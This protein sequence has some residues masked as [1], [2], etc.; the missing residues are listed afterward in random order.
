M[1]SFKSKIAVKIINYFFLNPEASHYVNELAR[2]LE[3]DPKNVYR[4]LR[5]LEKEGLF[6]SEFR[7]QQ[8]YFFIAKDYPLLKHYRQ[9]FLKTYG[10]EA[11][12]K[13]LMSDI[14]DIDEAYVYGSYASGKMDASSDID[15]L[16]VGSHSVIGLQKV[17]VGLQKEIGREINVVNLSEKEFKVKKKQKDQFL[18]NIFTGDH[19]KLL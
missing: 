5:E 2:L 17:I 14:P 12:L 7:G 4:K 15:L 11:E 8:R 6:R 1:I 16:V 19:I 13:K 18:K 9:I 10:I 3:L